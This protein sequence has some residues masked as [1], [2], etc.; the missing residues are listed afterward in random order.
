M[1]NWPSD[2]IIMEEGTSGPRL[3]ILLEGKVSVRKRGA[4]AEGQVIAELGPGAVLGEMSLLTD[5]PRSAS[6][7]ALTSLRLFAIDRRNFEEMARDADP[8]ALKVGLAI[9]RVLA[10]RVATLNQRLVGHLDAADWQH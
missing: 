5:Q 8:A 10:Q 4:D 3:V 7:H 1:E 9:S 6:V 2:S